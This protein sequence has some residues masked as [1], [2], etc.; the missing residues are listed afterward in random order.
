MKL[1]GM[2]HFLLLAGLLATAAVAAETWPQF[3]GP[4]GQGIAS[5]PGPL[6]WS[7]DTGIAWK[8]PLA[9]HGWSSPVIADGKIVLT[10]SRNEISPDAATIVFET[11]MAERT[12][13]SPVL[14]G[15]ALYIRTETHLWKIIGE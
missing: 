11:D 5:G 1:F 10:G 6:K 15:G 8:I 4:T 13:A 7:K 14:L 2:G 12:L 9:A 3:R